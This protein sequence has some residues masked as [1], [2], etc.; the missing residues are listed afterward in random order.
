[1][2]IINI[3]KN[4]IHQCQIYPT[5]VKVHMVVKP[6]AVTVMTYVPIHIDNHHFPMTLH[7]LHAN[8]QL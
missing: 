7:I 5:S 2:I 8:H 6:I 4:I 1:M 3:L